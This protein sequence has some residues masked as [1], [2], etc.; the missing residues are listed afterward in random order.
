[1]NRFNLFFQ[2]FIRVFSRK[3]HPLVIFLDDL[4]WADL[5]SLKLIELC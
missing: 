2:I 1:Q 3:E 5:P 4:Q